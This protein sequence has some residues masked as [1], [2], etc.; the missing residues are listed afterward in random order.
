MAEISVSVSLGECLLKIG[1]ELKGLKGM[2]MTGTRVKLGFLAFV[3]TRS[4]IKTTWT[5]TYKMNSPIHFLGFVASTWS[6]GWQ[7]HS[8]EPG[9]LLHICSQPWSESHSLMSAEEFHLR[10]KAEPDYR[11]FFASYHDNVF[12]RFHPRWSLCSKNI[13]LSAQDHNKT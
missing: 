11:R 12:H 4:I 6:P 1:S 9:K 7:A 2:K 8:K 13:E 10:V 3:V 5:S